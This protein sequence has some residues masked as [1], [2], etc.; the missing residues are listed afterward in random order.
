MPL[1]K[2]SYATSFFFLDKLTQ[3]YFLRPS[4]QLPTWVPV[5]WEQSKTVEHNREP[6]TLPR[7]EAVAHKIE[8]V[9]EQE[10]RDGGGMSFSWFS[11]KQ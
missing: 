8:S 2:F 9:Q 11:V 1:E 4:D 10:A 6:T 7:T 3:D 5:K